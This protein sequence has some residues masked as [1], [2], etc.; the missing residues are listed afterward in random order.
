M[1]IIIINLIFLNFYFEKIHPKYLR[2]KKM[3]FDCLLI[4]L[5]AIGQENLANKLCEEYDEE[6]LYM[7]PKSRLIDNKQ[8]HFITIDDVPNL[9]RFV[10]QTGFFY[11]NLPNENY[12]KYTELY[13]PSNY[14]SIAIEYI[15]LEGEILIQRIFLSEGR[16]GKLV[17]KHEDV[18][19]DNEKFSDILIKYFEYEA[20]KEG[21]V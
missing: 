16:A 21:D 7:P 1:K 12:K 14:D 8:T 9:K 4:F 15:E 10:W 3:L 13:A 17:W 11:N 5:V 2:S 6:I 18:I 19:F 20:T